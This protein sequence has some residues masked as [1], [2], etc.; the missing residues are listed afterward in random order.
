MLK[1]FEI[2]FGMLGGLGVFLYGLLILSIGFKKIWSKKIKNILENITK[3]RIKGALIGALVTS[4]IQSS[5]LVMV[6]LIGLLNAGFLGL[7]EA[8]SVMLG[9]EVGTTITAQII[10]FKIGIL[11][12][13]IVFIGS[14]LYFFA[15][16]KFHYIGQIILGFGLIF[17]GM[18]LMSQAAKP[19]KEMPAVLNIMLQLGKNP[20]L[21]VVIGAAIT[22]IFQSSS[23]M[24]GLIIAL[25]MEKLIFLPSAVVLIFGAN[26]GT[27]ITSILASLHSSKN[28]KRLAL[29][30][31]FV[32]VLGSIFF[33]LFFSS[34]IKF[35]SLTSPSL[36]R[37]IANSHTVFNIVTTILG[38]LFLNYLEKI[39]KF[40]VGGK[41][42]KIERGVKF[43]EEK[44]LTLPSLAIL[45]AEKEILRMAKIAKEILKNSKNVIL[46]EKEDLI[47]EIRLKEDMIDELHHL[48][49]HYL[50]KISTL[51][52]SKEEAER[53]TL[54]LHI[55]TDIERVGD[56]VDNFSEFAATK[57]NRK[58]N[59]SNE[60]QK[61][62]ETMFDFVILAFSLSI[63]ALEKVDKK[64]S[65]KVLKIE[66]K[67]N[68]MQKEYE[69]R[70]FE[71][72]KKKICQPE[73]GPLYLEIL[74]NLE[75][76]GDHSKNI[77][78]GLIMGF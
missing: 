34:Y 7:R 69:V 2:L 51:D 44:T 32:N 71:R 43:L 14:F 40:V 20:I 53:V 74:A 41:E 16:E 24:T 52:L 9:A 21:G 47:E 64:I 22:A 65:Q 45:Q 27:C 70:H 50:T 67:I 15:K 49:D 60:A 54:F 72:L 46:N 13:P 31:L 35:I 23:V 33:L 56:H 63:E 6:T 39:A 66:E 30:Q 5:S 17:L 61:E 25:S 12:A 42:I 58:I 38:L 29:A 28:S 59:F 48:I 3:N 55:V 18:T 62:I 75:R 76:I 26:I 1:N 4:I 10:A 68:R 19:I 37:Q 73:A 11:W 78:S 8:L 77:A 57:M 36:P